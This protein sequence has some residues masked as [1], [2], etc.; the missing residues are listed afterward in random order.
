MATFKM[1]PFNGCARGLRFS[2]SY[3]SNKRKALGVALGYREIILAKLLLQFEQIDGPSVNRWHV[4][5]HTS[6]M[7]IRSLSLSY[8]N[9]SSRCAHQVFSRRHQILHCRLGHEGLCL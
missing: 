6:S 2:C 8:F 9:A 1:A 3:N 4:I 5:M 7:L